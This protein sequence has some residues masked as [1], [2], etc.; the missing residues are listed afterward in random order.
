[1]RQ[2]QELKFS[3]HPS[4]ANKLVKFLVVNQEFQSVKDLQT[5]SGKL[6]EDLSTTRREMTGL[7]KSN[8]TSNNKIDQLQNDLAALTKRVKA[9]E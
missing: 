3:N 6:K 7:L 8:Q 1:M 5:D 4:V 9:L 2:I